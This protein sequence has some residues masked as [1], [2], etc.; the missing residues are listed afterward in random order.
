MGGACVNFKAFQSVILAN[1]QTEARVADA[2]AVIVHRL[3]RSLA[4]ETDGRALVAAFACAWCRDFES[5]ANR[6]VGDESSHCRLLL[7]LRD[8][9][10]RADCRFAMATTE[11]ATRWSPRGGLS[12]WPMLFCRVEELMKAY[13]WDPQRARRARLIRLAAAVALSASAITAPVAVLLAAA[14]I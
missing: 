14:P 10:I 8:V 11:E 5:I 13:E 9:E 6:D 4:A 12:G 3:V 2:A 1:R 7:N